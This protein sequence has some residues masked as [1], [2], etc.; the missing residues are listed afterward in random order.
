MEK[1]LIEE[2]AQMQLLEQQHQQYLREEKNKSTAY[3][4]KAQA[5]LNNDTESVETKE[6]ENRK[7]RHMEVISSS[8]FKVSTDAKAM[9]LSSRIG[10]SRS[11]PLR[12]PAMQVSQTSEVLM[13]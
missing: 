5:E 10:S 8:S 12:K 4:L 1:K 13:A 11:T 9:R 7:T 3:K 2:D 6:Y